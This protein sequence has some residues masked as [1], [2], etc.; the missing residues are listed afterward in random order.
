MIKK[1]KGFKVTT[2]TIETT[3]R[4]VAIDVVAEDKEQAILYSGN[5]G[6]YSD[7]PRF[8]LARTVETVVEE[9]K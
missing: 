1:E 3:K 5:S 9:N 8:V 7:A 2:T 4:V 6:T